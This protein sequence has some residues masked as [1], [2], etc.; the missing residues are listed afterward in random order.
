MVVDIQDAFVSHI[1]E[2]DR[3][4]ERSRVMIKA[5]QLLQIPLV[6]T[7]QYPSGLGRTVEALRVILDTQEYY[8]KNTFSCFQDET[9]KREILRL[10]RRQLLLIGIEAHICLA[11]TAYD[12][13]ALGLRPYLAVDAISSRRPGD[14]ELAFRQLRQAGAILTSTEA[15]IMEMTQSSKHPAFRDI[16]QL[17]K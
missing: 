12:A 15:A 8:D 7:E 13:M 16:S 10:G 14:A 5:A 1:H 6:V 9:I 3:V 17:V 2:M 11:Q 4:I